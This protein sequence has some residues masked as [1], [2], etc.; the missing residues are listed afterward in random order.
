[1]YLMLASSISILLRHFQALH[2]VIATPYANIVNDTPV[3]TALYFRL[4]EKNKMFLH[5]FLSTRPF[6]VF[7]AIPNMFGK[8]ESANVLFQRYLQ[9][10]H[11]ITTSF[12]QCILVGE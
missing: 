2:V 8:S 1:M 3:H 4:K 12:T 10:F 11:L 7:R 5:N 6:A 9:L